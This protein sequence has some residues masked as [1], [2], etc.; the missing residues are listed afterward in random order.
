MLLC[1]SHY[2]LWCHIGVYLKVN[3]SKLV[4]VYYEGNTCLPV[5]EFLS[6]R[7]IYVSLGVPIPVA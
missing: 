6:V 7:L 5:T 1:I 3:H 2:T 4:P